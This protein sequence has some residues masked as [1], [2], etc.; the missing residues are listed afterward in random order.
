MAK[1]FEEMKQRVKDIDES[2]RRVVFVDECLFSSKALNKNAYSNKKENIM[3][4]QKLIASKPIAL[5][6]AVS[7]EIGVEAYMTYD[8]SLNS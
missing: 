3:L 6:A 7:R 8:N 4:S 1:L 2:E 5:V